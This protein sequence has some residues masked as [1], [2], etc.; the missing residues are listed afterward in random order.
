MRVAIDWGIS[1][2]LPH[3]HVQGHRSNLRGLEI[4]VDISVHPERRCRQGE[5]TE[6]CLK[7]GACRGMDIRLKLWKR[8]N[9]ELMVA[10]DE[11]ARGFSDPA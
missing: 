2:N 10:K 1:L 8:Q 7:R 11:S 3:F 5:R 9:T 6:A 4:C